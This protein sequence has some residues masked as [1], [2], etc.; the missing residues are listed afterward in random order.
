MNTIQI[1]KKTTWLAVCL[2]A[3]LVALCG[4]SSDYTEGVEGTYFKTSSGDIFVLEHGI[5]DLYAP[6][7]VDIKKIK[8]QLNSA[9]DLTWR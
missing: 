3:L 5:G 8:E 4:C 6:K 7:K 2:T 9:N 1:F